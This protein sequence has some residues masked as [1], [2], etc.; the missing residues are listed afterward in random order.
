MA[1]RKPEPT[2]PIVDARMP[3]DSPLSAAP[4]SAAEQAS[5]EHGGLTAAHDPCKMIRGWNL[6]SLRAGAAL[7]AGFEIIYFILDR[8][9][10]SPLTPATMAPHAGA[11]GITLLL[12]A[13]TTSKWFERHWRP[14]CFA[15]LLA[16]YGLTLVLRL[17]TGGAEPLL[18]T[19][20]L[21][22][23]G[24]GALLPWSAAGSCRS[25]WPD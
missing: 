16:I 12:V 18:I 17:L 23:I 24:T 9:I 11:V 6:R 8:Y 14:V 22:V 3:A 7:L 20:M 4:A 25:A 5:R 2:D 13:L 15:T 10:S 1:V 21:T 19:M